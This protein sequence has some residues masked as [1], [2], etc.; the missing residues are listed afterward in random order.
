MNFGM[1]KVLTSW[2][3]PISVKFLHCQQFKDFLIDFKVESKLSQ[4]AFML[5]ISEI[6]TQYFDWFVY[7]IYIK[8]VMINV[9]FS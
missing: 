3:F 9:R 8:S 6:D 4:F 2:I 7:L 5:I 1:A